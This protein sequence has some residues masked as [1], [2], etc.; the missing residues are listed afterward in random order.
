MGDKESPRIDDWQPAYI[1]V[2]YDPQRQVITHT[3]D[4]EVI[5]EFYLNEPSEEK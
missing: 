5:K 3:R 4:G 1:V 2:S